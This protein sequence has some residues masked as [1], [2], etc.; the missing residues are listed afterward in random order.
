MKLVLASQ[1]LHKIR[2]FREMFS[3]LKQVDFTTLLQFPAYRAPDEPFHTFA[4]NALQKARHAA[5]ALN[6]W[7]IGDDS[8]LVVPKLKGA[9]GVI[10]S[11]YAG[12]GATDMDNRKKLMKEMQG[13]AD[14]ERAAYFECCI[15]LV[16][17]DGFEKCFSG[18]CEGEIL[19]EE[20]GRN[21]FGYDS[22]FLKHDYDKSFAEMD[23][24]T[25]NRISHRRKAFDKLSTALE[26]S[27][28]LKS[29]VTD[30]LS[31]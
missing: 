22:L 31:R 26:M 3:S 30:A 19:C 17:P 14:L 11:H 18:I 7:A 10:S 6:M 8:G 12:E 13:L 29:Q 9:P 4:E 2:E 1:N 23:E 16:G 21:G 25:K 27:G 5:K 28:A 24:S 20:R 15:A